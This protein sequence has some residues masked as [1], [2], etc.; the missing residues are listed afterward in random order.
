MPCTTILVGKK[1]S[2]DSSTIIA[3]N[4]DSP[5]GVFHSKKLVK[6]PA[7]A[8]SKLYK[9]KISG[10]QIPL[11]ENAL[12]YTA[13]PN[14]D[15]KEGLWL[16]AG[17]N[18]EGVAMTATETIT[19]NPRVLGADP[20]IDAIRSKKGTITKA[21]GIGEEDLVAIVLPFIHTAR[22]GV[23][24]LGALLEK[25]GTYENNGIA[26]SDENEIFYLETIGGHHFIAKR[27]KDDEYVTMPNQFGID[28]FSFSDAYG[29]KKENICSSDLKAFIAK[30]NL[31]LTISGSFNPREAFGSH[32]DSDH[33]YN[34]PRAWY[35]ERYLSG[36]QDSFDGPN[37]RY[38][39]LSDDLPFSRKPDKK[40][41]IEDVKYLLSSHYQSTPFDPYIHE[42][43]SRETS[44]FRPIGIS[45]TSFLAVIEIRDQGKKESRPIEWFSF[46]SNVFN[47]L[48]LFY[49]LSSKVPAYYSNTTPT[50]SSASLYWASRIIGALADPYYSKTSTFIDRYEELLMGKGHELVA[51]YDDMFERDGKIE[52]L[53]K[54]N[55]EFADFAKAATDSLLNETLYVA[56]M[57]MRNGFAKSD[58]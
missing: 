47:S 54:A 44:P 18:S 37:A 13:M 12:S 16:A 3:R 55:K 39:P 14:V 52:D 4:D 46:G 7:K 58:K 41:T 26:F 20:L 53:D 6:I 35:I 28:N 23:I 31:D 5:S 11:P 57:G 22:E 48:M 27:V 34:T 15:P 8:A 56:S 25:Y 9:S 49:P 50:V 2:Y 10:V 51:K 24:R 40:I 17:V 42:K 1:A 32:N 45:R 21:G 19:T 29:A 43:L 30:N 36:K 33:V 38:T